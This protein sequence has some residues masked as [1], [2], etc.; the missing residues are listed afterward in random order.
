VNALAED[1]NKD[2]WIGTY[3]GGAFRLHNGSFEQFSKSQGLPG[4]IVDAILPVKDGAI[5]IGTPDGISHMENGHLRNFSVADGLSSNH[6]DN[7]YQDRQG[8]LWAAMSSGVNRFSAGHFTA[9][10]KPSQTHDYRILMEDGPGELYASASPTSI[11]RIDRNRLIPVAE[12][13]K[14]AGMIRF[15]DD[16]WVCGE[17]L[18]R[19]SPPALPQWEHTHESPQDYARY[20]IGDG[21]SST[22][23]SSGSPNLAITSDDKLWAAMLNGLAMIDLTRL[24]RK[25]S[26]PAIYMEETTVGRSVQPPG[27][28]LVLSPGPHHIELHFG[29][30]ELASPEKIHMQYRLDGVDSDWLDASAASNAVYS[31]VPLGTH[32]FHVRACNRDGVWDRVGITYRVTQLPYFYETNLFRLA[33]LAIFGMILAGAY[34][35]RLSRLTAEMNARLDER[36]LERTRLA[37]DLHDTLIQTIH[38]TKMV[39]DAG[40]DDPKDPAAV[41]RALQRV[42]DV[43]EQ[44]SQEGRAALTALRASALQRNDLAEALEQAAEDFVSKNSMA[45]SLMVEGSARDIHPIVR[46]EVYRIA[47]EAMRNACSHSKGTGL[48]VKLSYARGLAIRVLDDGIGIEKELLAKGREGHFGINGMRERAERIGAILTVRSSSFGTEVE[49][50]VPRKVAFRENKVA[51]VTGLKK[52]RRFFRWRG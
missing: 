16:L 22:E 48:E 1:S 6:T 11:F 34:R 26:K 35:Y 18:S 12:R 42:S 28:E 8:T 47:Y 41:H 3:F 51:S 33:V 19:V 38:G 25:S 39:A 5:W 45:F 24:P 13:P 15:Q 4:D 17:G 32:T 2:I 31:G 37:R 40:L 20:G 30:I 29:V 7:L 49:L 23:C 14:A 52:L 9:I 10:S 36:V 44:A 21:L 46:D 43:L 50:M 27:H